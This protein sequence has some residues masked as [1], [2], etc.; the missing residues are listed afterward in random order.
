MRKLS[1]QSDKHLAVRF[2]T[3]TSHRRMPSLFACRDKWR[4]TAMK[5]VCRHGACFGRATSGWL[6]LEK[7]LIRRRNMTVKLRPGCLSDISDTRA[8]WR[9]LSAGCF[10]S[11][12]GLAGP[13]FHPCNDA[14]LACLVL[15]LRNTTP[16]ASS[17]HPFM[18][19]DGITAR[20]QLQ[21][22]RQKE[23]YAPN[24]ADRQRLK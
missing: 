7:A 23:A 15:A 18:L 4:Q 20:H 16:A 6:V 10:F 21:A 5:H 9:G 17:A 14:Q 22:T 24:V 2:E 19:A 1:Y 3:R 11:S 12:C 13:L 8:R